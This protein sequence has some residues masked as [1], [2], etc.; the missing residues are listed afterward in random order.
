MKPRTRLETSRPS[1]VIRPGVVKSPRL[2]VRACLFS[3]SN[4]KWAVTIIPMPSGPVHFD[5]RFPEQ[6][7]AGHAIEHVEHSVAV[8]PQHQLARIVSAVQHWHWYVN[9]RRV[10]PGISLLL[11]AHLIVHAGAN[12]AIV[13]M[14]RIR[15]Q[16]TSV[17]RRSRR[18]AI[19]RSSPPPGSIVSDLRCWWQVTR[20]GH[21]RKPEEGQRE[22]STAA[23]VCPY[24]EPCPWFSSISS[25]QTN[26]LPWMW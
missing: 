26:R 22:R 18:A 3:C 17:R 16:K 2:R 20:Y 21:S 25:N 9:S 8:G 19:W 7:F 11:V 24:I 4:L 14:Q 12:F 15:A 6:E 5:E 23:Q 10:I 1:A 13:F